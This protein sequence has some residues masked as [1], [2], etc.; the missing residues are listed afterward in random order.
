MTKEN[1]TVSVIIPTYNRAHLIGRAI[2]SVLNQTYRDFELII[3]DD[4]ST[5]NTEEVVGSFKD[6]RIKYIHH[7]EN[8]GGT[9]ARNTGINDANGEYI[10]FLD[11][12]DEWLPEKLEKQINCFAK[13][14]D[15]VGAV[16]CLHYTKDDSLGYM[17]QAS[18]SK[19]KRGNVYNFLLNGWCP[20]STSLFMLSARVFE[21]SGMFDDNL[22]SFQD[23]DL[24]VRVARH[25]EFEFVDEP[26]VVKH[27][28][29]GSQVAK[30][31]TPRMNGLELFLDKWG[32]VIKKEA[33]EQAFNDI[34][35]KHLS[36]IYRNAVLDSLLASQRNEAMKYLKRLWE[37]KSLSLKFLVK[38]LIVLLGGTKLLN[39]SR[40]IFYTSRFAS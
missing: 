32:D 37:L 33:G 40:R 30:D 28:H 21:K 5:D 12:D 14:S 20:S 17:Q 7:K 6:S 15:S 19:L 1:P 24:W 9:A 10:A 27:Q 38:V 18:L 36:A 39:F 34:R 29:L 23:Y 35:R 13:C 4:G 3:V 11:S 16:Y 22:P 8:K 2:Q 26:L 25:Y 31:F